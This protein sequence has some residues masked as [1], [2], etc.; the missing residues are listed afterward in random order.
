MDPRPRR[1]HIAVHDASPAHWQELRELDSLLREMGVGTYSML[2]IPDYHGEYPLEK[3]PDFCSWLEDLREAGVEM[4]LHGFTHISRSVPEGIIDRTRA[5]LFTRGEGEFLGLDPS[6]AATLLQKGREALNSAEIFTDAFVAP[7]W[8]YSRGTLEALSTLG[9]RYAEDRL[10]SW[11]PHTGRV[12]LRSPVVNFA[13]GGRLKRAAATAWVHA[14]LV[15]MRGTG[16][17]RFAL[18]PCDLARRETVLKVMRALLSYRTPVSAF[19]S[20][21]SPPCSEDVSYN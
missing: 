8:L 5:A 9:F 3:Y 14:S 2:V 10:H 20:S 1:I 15:L 12:L 6:S 13:G 18:H 19:S 16:T 17:L 11:D 21:S 4:M 7:A